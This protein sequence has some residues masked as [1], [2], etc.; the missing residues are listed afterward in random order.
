VDFIRKYL[1][2]GVEKYIEGIE[3]PI[4]KEDALNKLQENG[5]P[6]MVINQL[7]QR[8]PEGE[9]GSPQEVVDALKNQGGQG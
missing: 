2:G 8:L 4:G 5:A 3:F 6:G 7:Q 1:P 9:Y